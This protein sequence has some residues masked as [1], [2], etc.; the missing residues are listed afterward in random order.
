MHTFNVYF[1]FLV[2]YDVLI[3]GSIYWTLMSW[4]GAKY[5]TYIISF[6]LTRP[7]WKYVLLF[8]LIL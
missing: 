7:L 6:N 8:T 2:N 4:Q 3:V 1:Y 5:F